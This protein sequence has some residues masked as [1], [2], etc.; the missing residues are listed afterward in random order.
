MCRVQGTPVTS[1]EHDTLMLYIVFNINTGVEVGA[2]TQRDAALSF[3][4]SV[5]TMDHAIVQH[6]EG[7]DNDLG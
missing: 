2:F 5:G 1:L 6:S 4:D 3:M 7:T